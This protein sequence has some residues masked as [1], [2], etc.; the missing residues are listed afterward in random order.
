M[1]AWQARSTL[2]AAPEVVP[3][4]DQAPNID[5]FNL[6]ASQVGRS[7]GSLILQKRIP[8]PEMPSDLQTASHTVAN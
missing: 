2:T 3:A 6:T 8:H 5:S 7:S 4:V 1:S